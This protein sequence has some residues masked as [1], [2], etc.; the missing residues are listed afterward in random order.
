MPGSIWWLSS[1]QETFDPGA[2]F[3]AGWGR[4]AGRV[5][6]P[7][8]RGLLVSTQDYPRRRGGRRRQKRHPRR[9]HFGV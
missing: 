6:E 1:T 8:G 7:R 3:L 9:P 5:L 2:V 4:G